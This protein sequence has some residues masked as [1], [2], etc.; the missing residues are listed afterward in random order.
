MGLPF[1]AYALRLVR[2]SLGGGGSL[3][4]VER[5]KENGPNEK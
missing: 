5:A 2:R 4:E 1:R 3:S